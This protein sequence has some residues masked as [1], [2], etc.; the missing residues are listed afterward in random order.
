MLV[1]QKL[2]AEVSYQ[3]ALVETQTD[4]LYVW[5]YPFGEAQ[6]PSLLTLK[7]VKVARPQGMK[8]NRTRALSLLPL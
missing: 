1:C 3:C 4:P 8:S 6:A 2:W 7:E 5:G